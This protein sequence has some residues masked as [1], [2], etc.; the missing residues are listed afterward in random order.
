MRHP[1][2]IISAA[3]IVAAVCAACVVCAEGSAFAAT[4]PAGAT[5]PGA[6]HGLGA[7]P[8]TKVVAPRV[9]MLETLPASADLRQW[10]V[11]PGDQG[12]VGSCVTWA[13]DYAMLGWYSRYA[14]RTGQP[15]APMYTYSQINGGVDAGSVPTAALQLG[16]DQGTDTRADY[17]QGD[18][19][20]RHQ[21]TAA[22]HANA[23]RYKIK[24][25]ETL[26]MGSNQ[27]GSATLLRHALSTLHPV[28][29]EMAV[30]HGFDSLA[31]SATAVDG[32]YTS[33]VR[34][35]HEV[36]AVG[37]DSA[38][39]TIQNSWGA[40]WAHG[41]FGRISWAVVQHDVWEADTIDGLVPPP[42]P[43]APSTSA[44]IAVKAGTVAKT[45]PTVT[46]KIAWTAAAG[47]SGAIVR[48]E[49]WYQ[50]DGRTW[51]PVRLPSA[52]SRTFTIRAAVGHRYRVA[53]RADSRTT[54]G[55]LRYGTT[56]LATR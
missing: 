1:L 19:D 44:P 10:A 8:P 37:Y 7:L 3:T 25:Y 32:D 16:V 20:W 33:A 18:Y 42:A 2:R 52:T 38:G 50:A 11:T 41:G 22:E 31:S 30:R 43:P 6:I 26:F 36:L 27:S 45:A 5:A 9:A 15:F 35:Y 12:Q 40:G 29:I 53:V 4:G 56:F 23:A 55:A 46:Y 13:I 17:T 24:G 21:P 48:F 47:T 28:A 34:G 54:I 14:N 49:A 39:L 51:I